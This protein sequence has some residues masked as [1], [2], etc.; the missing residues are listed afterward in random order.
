V[1]ASN[2]IYAVK[3][4]WRSKLRD[5]HVPGEVSAMMGAKLAA[6]VCKHVRPLFRTHR[7]LLKND[8]GY[9]E[10]RRDPLL[11]LE[12]ENGVSEALKYIKKE[13]KQNCTCGAPFAGGTT[14]HL[15]IYNFL[16]SINFEI[17]N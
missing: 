10:R 11:S 9:R 12:A 6:L 13:R 8:V 3:E 5:Y 1:Q 4:A 16:Q 15:K 14:P 2:S 17:L 7:R